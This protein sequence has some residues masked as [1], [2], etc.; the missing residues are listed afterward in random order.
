MNIYLDWDDS[1]I[2]ADRV[3]EQLHQF[4]LYS[5]LLQEIAI[6][7]LIEKMAVAWSIDLNDSSIMAKSGYAIEGIEY[8]YA[9]LPLC[10]GMNEKQL[11]AIYDRELR[12]QKFKL[13]KWGDE[14]ETY[15]KSYAVELDR[16]LISI[17]QVKDAAVAQELFFRIQAGEKSFAEIAIDHSQGN[18]A[19]NG[20]IIGPV[21]LGDLNPGIRQILEG[22]KPGELS[23]LFQI[24]G[25]YTFIRLDKRELAI[26]D[27]QRYQFLLDRLFSN[28]LKS[29]I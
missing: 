10:E 13:A 5:Q 22:L 16:V 26:L 8:A 14:V 7:D 29:Q 17:L 23:S 19:H 25:Y 4:G 11:K 21:L 28:W 15:F 18:Y 2:S 3:I 9:K 12:L 20:G 6:N 1:H 24:D 27:E